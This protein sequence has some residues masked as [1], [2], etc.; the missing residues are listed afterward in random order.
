MKTT[1]ITAL[2]SMICIGLFGCGTADPRITGQ[3]QD[4]RGK[5][6]ADLT[7][8]MGEPQRIVRSTDGSELWE[9]HK[10]NDMVVPKGESTSFFGGGNNYGL[11][12]AF[13]SEKRP[14]D[15]TSSVEHIA[16]FKIF[17][18]TIVGVYVAR[19]IDGRTVMENHW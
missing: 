1:Q 8:F 16:R 7:Q 4:W 10:V 9:Y 17:Q 18:G 11:S 5:P 12:G 6:A 15:R 19:F 2:L 13:S 14:E 3:M